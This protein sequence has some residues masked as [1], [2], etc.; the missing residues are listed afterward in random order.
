MKTINSQ[1]NGFATS[2][3]PG[4]SHPAMSTN[5]PSKTCDPPT[6]PDTHNVISSPASGSGPM[7]FDKLGGLTIAEFGQVVAHANLSARQAKVVGWLTSGIS[8]PHGFTSSQPASLSESTAS[9]LRAKTDLLGS[10][11]FSLTW[12]ERHTPSKRPICAL[13]ASAR[14]TSDNDSTGWPTAQASD[15]TG[16]GQYARTQTQR[17]N[18]KDHALL[19]SWQ[20]ATTRDWK[21]SASNLHGVNARPLNEVAR[22]ASWPTTTRSDSN[23]HPGQNFTT[24]NITLNH[25]ALFAASGLPLNGSPVETAKP[26]QLNPAHSRW[27]MGL[28]PAW[29]D[30]AATVTQSSRRSRSNG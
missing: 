27:L 19:A 4:I 28:P 23:R 25:A 14:R 20:S 9:K 12:K 10:T 13:R 6:L 30:C 22:L 2:S 18:L 21:S 1:P 5:D 11:L 17:R 29:D 15:S 26:G 8:G 7:R 3:Q 16:G 24:S